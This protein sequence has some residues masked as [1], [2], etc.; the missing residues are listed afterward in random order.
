MALRRLRIADAPLKSQISSLLTVLEDDGE[1]GIRI[2]TLAEEV[3]RLESLPYVTQQVRLRSY[4]DELLQ[5]V[6]DS[7][8]KFR[9]RTGAPW[10]LTR[11]L[12]AG[13]KDN[14][15]WI[16][17]WRKEL[18][19]M[20]TGQ[21]SE[22]RVVAAVNAALGRFPEGN[23]PRAWDITQVLIDGL[24]NASSS[25]RA[26]SYAAL[27]HIANDGPCFEPTDP[28]GDFRAP[29]VRAW[30]SWAEANKARLELRTIKQSFW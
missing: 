10:L 4:R 18:E 8:E 6:R 20:L 13:E 1:G 21:D 27:G 23:D 22:L 9:A 11:V 16:P 7:N 24:N 3:S 30:K 12:R 15:D 5:I 29:T 25:V 26:M 2:T 19:A 28:P 14:P 17:Q